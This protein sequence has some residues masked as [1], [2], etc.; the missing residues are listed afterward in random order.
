M[1]DY[2]MLFLLLLWYKTKNMSVGGH[3]FCNSKN[4]VLWAIVVFSNRNTLWLFIH[5]IDILIFPYDDILCFD[6]FSLTPDSKGQTGIT[7]L[8]TFWISNHST[9]GQLGIKIVDSGS[10][11]LKAYYNKTP[12]RHVCLLLY[13]FWQSF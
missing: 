13:F 4:L 8:R 6:L 11:Y 5:I 7:K 10:G 12:V 9:L 3:T 2:N 1:F